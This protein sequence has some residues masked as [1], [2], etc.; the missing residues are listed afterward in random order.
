MQSRC[1]ATPRAR[2]SRMIAAE[3]GVSEAT[4]SAWCKGAGVAIRQRK[5]RGGAPAPGRNP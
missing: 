4:L 1:T 2:R 5:P 3:L